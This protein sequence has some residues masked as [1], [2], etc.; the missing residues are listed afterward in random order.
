MD[1]TLIIMFFNATKYVNDDRSKL[2]HYY[3]DKIA[4]LDVPIVIWR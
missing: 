4:Y 1:C 3:D 2:E